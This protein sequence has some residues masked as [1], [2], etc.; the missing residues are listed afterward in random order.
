MVGG[1]CR[2]KLKWRKK[3]RK[4]AV[5]ATHFGAGKAAPQY[6]YTVLVLVGRPKI[7]GWDAKAPGTTLCWLTGNKPYLLIGRRVTRSANRG[8]ASTVTRYQ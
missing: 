6:W 3:R 4:L 7:A 5:R 8:G 1:W 2:Q